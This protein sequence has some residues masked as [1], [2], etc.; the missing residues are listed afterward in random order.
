[1]TARCGLII[2]LDGTMYHGGKMV[3]YADEFVS[4]LRDRKI[5]YLFL[6][7]N[8]SR[9]P[10][11]VAKQL[12]G[13]GIPADA[14][15]VYTSAQAA[16]SYIRKKRPGAKVYVLGEPGLHAALKEAGLQ[17]VTDEQP[18]Y[19]VQGIDFSFD[20]AK[21]ERAAGYIRSGA[22]FILTNPD[23]LLPTDRGFIPGAGTLGAAI[24]AASGKQPVVIGK[25]ST[26]I[27]EDVIERI[28]L[29]ADQVWVVGDNAA[30]DMRAGQAAG[31]RTA[32]MLTGI[33]T[34]DN[35]QETLETAGVKPDLICD[36]IPALAEA[37]RS[38]YS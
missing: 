34:R 30:T 14:A 21:L 31:C 13:M 11:E 5:P 10:E 19:V 28:G 8:S 32:L 36:D 26:I 1:M 25:P 16:A 27:M 17:Q 18:D 35:L 15:Q 24:Q 22:D 38:F 37:L 3:A 6:T 23:L 7:N 29:P 33:T 2:D 9:T 12:T 20:Y 4:G